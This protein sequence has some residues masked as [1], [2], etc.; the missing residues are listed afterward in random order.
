[1]PEQDDN[2][3]VMNIGAPGHEIISSFIEARLADPFNAP[4]F[5]N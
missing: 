5:R 4:K 1:M 2:F 3:E